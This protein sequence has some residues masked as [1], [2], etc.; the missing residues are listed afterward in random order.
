MSNLLF[1]RDA[2]RGFAGRVGAAPPVGRERAIDGLR[3]LAILGVVCGH[4]LVGALVAGPDGALAIDSPL[5]SIEWLA[6]ASWFLQMLG[7]FFLVGGYSAALS[8]R[9]AR[10]RGTPDRQWVRHRFARLGRPVLVTAGLLAGALPLAWFA[11]V[12][13]GTLHSEVL[14]VAQPL[15]FIGIYAI[16]TALTP[17][18]AAAERRL[19]WWSVLPL[20]AAVA[21]VDAARYGPLAGSVPGW[22]GYL[23]VLPAWLFTYQLGLAW[24][25]GRLRRGHAI[26]LFLGG[27]ALFATLIAWFEYP[28]SM[29]S[30]P[31]SGRSNSNPPS[32]LVPALASAQA[33]A[34][35]LWR[36]RLDRLLRRPRLWAVVAA[37]NLGAMTIFCWHQTALVTASAAGAALG[38][39]RGLTDA[40][41]GGGWLVARLAWFPVLGLVLAALVL[42]VRS[43]VERRR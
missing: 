43:R 30:V 4:W 28:L 19:G 18:L 40:P 38:G 24:A 26:L 27:A 13:F 7:L 32:L 5:R 35:L 2:A 9:R 34:A 31:G 37:L 21:V 39:L 36:D 25:A 16:L 14:L 17:L 22:L 20:V 8:L 3:A 41:D 10:Q 15:W 1:D 42:L 12:P 33:G 23:T 11:G 29:V 6:P